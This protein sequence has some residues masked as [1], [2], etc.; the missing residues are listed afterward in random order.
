MPKKKTT[1]RIH[2]ASSLEQETL[3]RVERTLETLGN[4]LAKWNSSKKPEAISGQVNMIKKFYTSL[5]NWKKEADEGE[6]EGATQRL[7]DFVLIC[8]SYEVK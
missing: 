8:R 4:F 2:D 6:R 5:Q 1:K 3:K 7:R